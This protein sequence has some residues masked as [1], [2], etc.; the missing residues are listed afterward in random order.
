MDE[1]DFCVELED[2]DTTW[3]EDEKLYNNYYLEDI[4][5]IKITN[6]YTNKSGEIEKINESHYVLKTPN[7]LTAG[8]LNSLLD[9]SHKPISILKYNISLESKDINK[10]L[11]NS[12]CI[13]F[14][15]NYLVT[16]DDLSN[17][18]NLN[19][20][21]EKTINIFQSLNNVIVIYGSHTCAK[22]TRKRNILV[23]NK[24]IRKQLKGKLTNI[25]N[26]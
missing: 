7:I 20:S 5:I 11:K 16:I 8:E 6:I 25:S 22:K 4:E 9:K 21:F 23:L 12:K 3:L 1:E 10:V 15:Q 2:L 17:I 24:T 14:L 19:I 18:S 13:D 26:K